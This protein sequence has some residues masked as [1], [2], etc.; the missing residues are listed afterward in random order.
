MTSSLS[1]GGAEALDLL[2]AKLKVQ[3]ELL[4]R[5]EEELTSLLKLLEDGKLQQN[6]FQR[7]YEER[8]HDLEQN[9]LLIE[10]ELVRRDEELHF[11]KLRAAEEARA[12]EEEY[13][14][15]VA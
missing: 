2:T 1:G 14:R 10:R 8:Y 3:D 13:Q 12:K 11:E 4:R 15:R 6:R 9:K 7:T 5:K